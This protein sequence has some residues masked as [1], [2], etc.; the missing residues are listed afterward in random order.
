M[1]FILSKVYRNKTVEKYT[2]HISH[3][4]ITYIYFIVDFDLSQENKDNLTLNKFNIINCCIERLKSIS[5]SI[6]TEK[7][8][9]K[10]QR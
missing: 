7:V 6:D 4:H 1:N 2:I 10:I 5:I 8:T 3:T 9:N